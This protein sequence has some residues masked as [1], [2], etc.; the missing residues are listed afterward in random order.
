[1]FF[2]AVA[3]AMRSALVLAKHS[4]ENETLNNEEVV[5]SSL[6]LWFPL[7]MLIAIHGN[8]DSLVGG[9]VGLTLLPTNAVIAD[10][11]DNRPTICESA[12]ISFFSSKALRL[13]V[14]SIGQGLNP[15]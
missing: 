4:I 5:P 1:V 2:T 3:S 14:T 11:A 13:I 8:G 6:T 12:L 10:D 9:F 7:P 15:C